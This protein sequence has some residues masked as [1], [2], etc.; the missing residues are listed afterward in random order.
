MRSFAHVI[1]DR[2]GLH[3]RSCVVLMHEASKWESEIVVTFAGMEADA[4]RMAPLLALHANQGDALV[5]SCE[6]VDED[7]AAQAMEALMKMSI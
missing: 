2:E 7:D 3:A 4:K 6:G 5:V 1:M